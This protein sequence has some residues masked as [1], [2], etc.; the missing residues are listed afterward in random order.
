M[1][2]RV[3]KPAGATKEGRASS[4]VVRCAA[5]AGGDRHCR[6]RDRLA[7]LRRANHVLPHGLYTERTVASPSMGTWATDKAISG[8]DG[9]AARPTIG[10]SAS[11]CPDSGAI[12]C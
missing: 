7:V 1:V 12:D 10:L 2:G 3:G 6:P 11:A 9:I 5:A 4:F 8:V